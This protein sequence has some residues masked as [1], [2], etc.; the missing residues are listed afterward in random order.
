MEDVNHKEKQLWNLPLWISPGE[1]CELEQLVIHKI[2]GR[3]AIGAKPRFLRITL[4]AK[5]ISWNFFSFHTKFFN[6]WNRVQTNARIDIEK[7]RHLFGTINCGYRWICSGMRTFWFV[8]SKAVNNS[9]Q[10][11][12]FSVIVIG[13]YTILFTPII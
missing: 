8:H 2:K 3:A 11:N 10:V 4:W 5:Q 7:N 9:S 1:P 12:D 6:G 13:N